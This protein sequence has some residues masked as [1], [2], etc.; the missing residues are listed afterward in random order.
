VRVCRS[1]RDNE[2][3]GVESGPFT[4]GKEHTGVVVRL[5]PRAGIVFAIYARQPRADLS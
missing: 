2:I 3:P 4:V 1:R 5:E